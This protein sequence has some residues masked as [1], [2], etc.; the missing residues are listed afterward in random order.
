[1]SKENGN[2][3][4]SWTVSVHAVTG[5]LL[6]SISTKHRRQEAKGGVTPLKAHKFGILNPLSRATHR[7]LP[8]ALALIVT[9][10]MVKLTDCTVL[11]APLFCS[12]AG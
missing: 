5:V 8:P 11:H 7:R 12:F 9:S 6:P 1:M 2:S 4:P 10:S 3:M